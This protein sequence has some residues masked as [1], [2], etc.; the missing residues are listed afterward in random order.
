M[1][2]R[3]VPL[4]KREAALEQIRIGRSPYDVAKELKITPQAVYQWIG[5]A[6]K[7]TSTESPDLGRR[8]ERLE[9]DL[10][11]LKQDIAFLKQQITKLSR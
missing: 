1:A 6:K 2:R 11:F 10:D 7:Q 3:K 9:N 4:E 8:L 5:A